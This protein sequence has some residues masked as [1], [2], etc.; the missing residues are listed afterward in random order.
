[1]AA[2]RGPHGSGAAA[3]GNYGNVR[4]IQMLDAYDASTRY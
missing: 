1:M 2:T 3:R 4:S